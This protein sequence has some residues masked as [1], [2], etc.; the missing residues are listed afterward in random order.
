MN[1]KPILLI[2]GVVLIAVALILS[3]FVTTSIA[4]TSTT[5]TSYELQD[6]D[7]DGS[8]PA[9]Y[10]DESYVS[11][12]MIMLDENG[13]YVSNIP[14]SFTYEQ[15]QV[16]TVHT[17]VA[18]DF[19]ST[20]DIDW[21]SFTY[22]GSIKM[23]QL[24]EGEAD[25]IQYMELAGTT[26]FMEPTTQNNIISHDSSLLRIDPNYPETIGGNTYRIKIGIYLTFSAID[27]SD[28]FHLMA[29]GWDDQSDT[30]TSVETGTEIDDDYDETDPIGNGGG[31]DDGSEV[32]AFDATGGSLNPIENPAVA[33]LLVGFAFVVVQLFTNK[34]K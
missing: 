10:N 9:L 27:T 13:D 19:T 3:T 32:V 21:T 6:P 29:Y 22:G 16:A 17:Q 5:P 28:E 30:W 31:G 26:Y 20:T 25:T 18:W 1:K 12:M 23:F 11:T 34:K 14:F 4:I 2:V 24:Y 8:D 7:I 15:A 33:T